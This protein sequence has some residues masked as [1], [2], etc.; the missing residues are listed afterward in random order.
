MP[1]KKTLTKAAIIEWL[2]ARRSR[3]SREW[4]RTLSLHELRRL[5]NYILAGERPDKW[6]R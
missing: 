4:L 3:M 2:Y 1:K 5:H 6:R